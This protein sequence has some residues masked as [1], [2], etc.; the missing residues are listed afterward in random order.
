[1]RTRVGNLGNQ[2][3]KVPGSGVG[4]SEE[5]GTK[6]R[7]PQDVLNRLKEGKILRP[8]VRM[9]QMLSDSGTNLCEQN[10]EQLTM[11]EK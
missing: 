4:P 3:I 5:K 9:G 1:V 11:E 10:A 2:Q 6:G 8:G 7:R